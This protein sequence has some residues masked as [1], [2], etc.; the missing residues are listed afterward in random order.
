MG[1]RLLSNEFV[2]DKASVSIKAKLFVI[3]QVDHE[4]N[5]IYFFDKPKMNARSV[6]HLIIDISIG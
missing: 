3:I 5:R 6:N 2:N 4:S 1:N